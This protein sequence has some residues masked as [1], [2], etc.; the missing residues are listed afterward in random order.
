MRWIFRCILLNSMNVFRV[1]NYFST[2]LESNTVGSGSGLLI[3]NNN[4]IIGQYSYQSSTYL[5]AGYRTIANRSSQ[6]KRRGHLFV[7]EEALFEREKRDAERAQQYM[8]D[9]KRLEDIEKEVERRRQELIEVIKTDGLE[10][11]GRRGEGLNRLRV[12]ELC[13]DIFVWIFVAIVVF[14]VLMLF[15]SCLAAII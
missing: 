3:N 13:S 4:N 6:K 8:E 7:N 10:P 12:K 5:V 11:A 14:L 15:I 9:K 2:Q 1:E